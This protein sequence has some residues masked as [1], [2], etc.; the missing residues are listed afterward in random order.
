M[1][2]NMSIA[3]MIISIIL[4]FA[5]PLALLIYFRV[6]CKISF[7]AVGIGAA[8]FIVFSQV[9]EKSMHY[10]ML[11]ANNTTAHLLKNPL[12]FAIYG[13]LAAGIFEE[14]GRFIGFK[15]FLKKHREW[16]D[17]MAY[18]IGHGG[19]EAILI[20]VLGN[21]NNIIYSKMINAGTFEKTLSQALSV[22]KL[23]QLKSSLINT[24]PIIFTVSGIERILAVTLQLGLSLLVLYSIKKRKYIFLLL[25]IVIHALVDFLAV[26]LA[27]KGAN[28]WTIEGIVLVFAVIS[29][30]FIVKSRKLFL[31]D[32]IQKPGNI[33]R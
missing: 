5:F 13:G 8:I 32:K 6:R 14:I 10:Y 3:A 11:Y 31:P 19:I 25:A 30:A 1:V 21:L 15:F 18:G 7:A 33:M 17:G 29:V 23:E 2:S 24:L 26:F 20:G 12:V 9:L 27:Q 16:K 4:S 28:T 22:S